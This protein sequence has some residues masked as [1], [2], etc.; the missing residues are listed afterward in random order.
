ME[1]VRRYD[2]YLKMH[3]GEKNAEGEINGLKG[4]GMN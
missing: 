1:A 2:C 4:V 3:G